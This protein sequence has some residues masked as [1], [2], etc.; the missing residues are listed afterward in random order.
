MKTSSC[1]FLDN[2][3]CDGST[4]MLV[5]IDTPLDEFWAALHSIK[6]AAMA[7][8]RFKRFGD[9]LILGRYQGLFG[10]VEVRP[11]LGSCPGPI[12]SLSG[13]LWTRRAAI[14]AEIVLSAYLQG[15][16]PTNRSND[17]GSE[18]IDPHEA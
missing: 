2:R 9:E 14:E 15:L 6:G 1:A 10:A 3:V 7:F 4:E 11:A 16:P 17:P 8:V 5:C 12:V 18:G 13:V